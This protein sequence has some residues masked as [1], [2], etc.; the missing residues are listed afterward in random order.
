MY[1]KAEL[2]NRLSFL[3][4]VHFRFLLGTILRHKD[5]L[6]TVKGYSCF[7][8]HSLPAEA[9]K[10]ARQLVTVGSAYIGALFTKALTPY[11]HI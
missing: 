10:D 7:I 5:V 9:L 2:E 6:G 3:P 8:F 4:L 1:P 11:L